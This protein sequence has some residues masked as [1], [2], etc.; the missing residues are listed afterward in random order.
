MCSTSCSRLQLAFVARHARAQHEYDLFSRNT[1]HQRTSNENHFLEMRAS[2][3]Q[4]SLSLCAVWH[5]ELSVVLRRPF[6][7]NHL[8]T[9]RPIQFQIERRH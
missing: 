7:K 4:N 6:K 8:M 5:V 1:N 9:S 2:K 3:H